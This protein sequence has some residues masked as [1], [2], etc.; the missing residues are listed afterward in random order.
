IRRVPSLLQ[1][2]VLATRLDWCP[3]S[4]AYSSG[5]SSAS[6]CSRRLSRGRGKTLGELERLVG[7]LPPA[8]VN[9]QRVPTVRHL[10][11]LCDGLVALLFLIG[12]VRDRPRDG[13]VRVGRDDQHRPPLRIRR[14]DLD[15]GPWIEVGRCG[16][17][18]RLAGTGDGVTK[19]E[20]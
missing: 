10:D 16:L 2:F 20:L 13:M 17:E 9:G 8:G 5:S 19:V 15:L 14:I 12:S 1:S 4:P 18:E 3:P 6:R 7:D 11:D